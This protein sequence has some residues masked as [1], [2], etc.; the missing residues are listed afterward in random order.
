MVAV[1]REGIDR[2]FCNGGAAVAK[3]P[4]IS[5]RVNAAIGKGNFQTCSGLYMGKARFRRFFACAKT[6]DDSQQK[7]IISFHG[8]MNALIKNVLK[9]L[10]LVK[11]FDD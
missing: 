4:I 10:K 2:I 11:R 7:E 8:K 1:G 3:F 6:K 9:D 5:G